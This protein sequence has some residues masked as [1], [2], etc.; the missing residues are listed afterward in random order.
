MFDD[1]SII[2]EEI[3]NKCGKV[4][5]R[6]R[7][8]Y[9]TTGTKTA[10]YRG[11]S[12]EVTDGKIYTFSPRSA[13]MNTHPVVHDIS[14]KWF[15][16]KF[17][18]SARTD[19][20]FVSSSKRQASEYGSVHYVFPIGGFSTIH[21]NRYNDLFI[22]MSRRKIKEILLQI[23]VSE[24]DLPGITKLYDVLANTH[25]NELETAIRKFLE[26]G[27][28]IKGKSAS[29]LLSTNEIMLITKKFIVAPYNDRFI[30]FMDSV[31]YTDDI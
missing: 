19:T 4:I 11:M 21:S 29:A 24:K 15:K 1:E 8:V 27:E 18:I 14:N 28:Y 22:D 16:D 23:G 3:I 17:G 13:P 26:D 9:N 5:N 10:F 7:D 2:E 31:V 25:P 6:L 30:D 12:S 20:L